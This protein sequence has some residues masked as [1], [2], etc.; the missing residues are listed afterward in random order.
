MSGSTTL[1]NALMP[2]G[3]PADVSKV[4]IEI[5]DDGRCRWNLFSGC[6]R[7]YSAVA[8]PADQPALIE[9]TRIIVETMTGER[10]DAAALRALDN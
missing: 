4:E 8:R 3:E 9:S 1:R 10:I 5:L 7:I 2:G 6:R